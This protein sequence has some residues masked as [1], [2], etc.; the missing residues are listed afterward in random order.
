MTFSYIFIELSVKAYK[1]G[2]RRQEVSF[3]ASK[4]TLKAFRAL[5]EL[6]TDIKNKDSLQG[7][8]VVSV[9]RNVKSRTVEIKSQLVQSTLKMRRKGV[10]GGRCGTVSPRC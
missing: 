10:S 6:K 7:T 5:V 1:N 8:C 3:E 4:K 2:K 9:R